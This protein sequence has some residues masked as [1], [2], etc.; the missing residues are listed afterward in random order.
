[1][2]KENKQLKEQL[3]K[4]GKNENASWS[5]IVSKNVKKTQ[6]QIDIINT[7]NN[8]E[9]AY[10]SDKV[11]VSGI[12]LSEGK[13]LDEKKLN[14]KKKIE[15]LFDAIGIKSGIHNVFGRTTLN[16]DFPPLIVVDLICERKMF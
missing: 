3:S 13:D 6:E 8:R 9:I 14:D 4:K 5:E 12:P 7:I 2:Q 1:M 10:K 11:V 15:K 16:K